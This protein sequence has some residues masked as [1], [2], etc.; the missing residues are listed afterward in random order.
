MADGITIEEKIFEV[1]I[2][3]AGFIALLGTDVKSNPCLY[4]AKRSPRG[5]AYPAVNIEWVSMNSTEKIP[6]E[7]GMINFFISQTT[8]STEQYKVFNSIRLAIINLLNR[9]KGEPLTDIDVGA[10]EGLRVVSILKTR[11]EFKYKE[12][13]D[14]FTSL[15]QFMVIKGED[16][17]FTTDYGSWICS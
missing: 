5:I 6:S 14:K 8:Q 17:D 13:Q 11:A 7:K 9:N 2:A 15:L 4:I 1:L 16:E 12:E 3:D 10:N